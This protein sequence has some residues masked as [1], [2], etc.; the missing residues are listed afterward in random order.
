[1]SRPAPVVSH[2]K[3]GQSP[4]PKH[5]EGR[6]GPIGARFGRRKVNRVDFIV[7]GVQKAGTTALH[8]FLRQHPH[9]ALSRDQALHFFDKEEHFLSPPDY[10][11]LHG[12]FKPGWRWRI[13]GE[14][15]AD[16]LYYPRALERIA[17][18][19][20]QMKLIVSL[21]NPTERAF[22]Q[23]NMRRDKGQEP[24]EFLDA[25]KRDQEIG[26]W[27]RP[28]G[29]GYIARSLYSPRLERVFGVFPREQVL[30]LKYEEFRRDPSPMLNRLFDFLGVQKLQRFKNKRRNVGSYS[31]KLTAEER[32]Y[33]ASIFEDDIEKTEQLLGWDC[34]DWRLQPQVVTAPQLKAPIGRVQRGSLPVRGSTESR[35]TQSARTGKFRW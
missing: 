22:S 23:W 11:I 9:V 19:N 34:N 1:M 3:I 10:R 17:D 32:E 15:T 27:K 6:G 24:L 4:T 33:G 26:I 29:N 16:Y 7:G 35:P 18:Y 8:D 12:N 30:V 31:R 13:A 21:R 20:P 5:G 2:S 25:L 28:R 14:V